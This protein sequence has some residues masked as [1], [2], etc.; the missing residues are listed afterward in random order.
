MSDRGLTHVAL[1]VSNLERSLAFSDKSQ[2]GAVAT[3]YLEQFE[4]LANQ[5]QTI[6]LEAFHSYEFEHMD[7]ISFIAPDGNS[8]DMA[9]LPH[10]PSWPCAGAG[11][12]GLRTIRP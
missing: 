5:E 2:A 8:T 4:E 3:W 9:T 12:C 1:P 7:R 10:G 6:K 11:A